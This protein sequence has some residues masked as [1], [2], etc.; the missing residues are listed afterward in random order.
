[1]ASRG[2]R[3][4]FIDNFDS[5]TYN[6]VDEF[7]KRG[8]VVEVYRNNLPLKKIEE[9]VSRFRPELIVISPGPSTPAKAGNS[10]AV[11]K[12]FAGKVPV[13]GV[14]LGEQ[15][16][17]EAFGG[18]V[19]KA[20]ET[21]HGKPSLVTHDGKGI[22]RGLSKPFQAGRYHSLAGQKI[23]KELEVSARSESG[24]VM[25][26][27]HR[28]FFMEGVQFHPESILTPEGGKI[29][30]NVLEMLEGEGKM[31]KEAISKVAEG[32]DLSRA[33]AKEVFDEIM[34]GRTSEDDIVSLLVAL[35]EKG[36]SIGE[37]Q[38]AA[39]SMRSV[40]ARVKAKGDVLDVVGTGGDGKNSFNVS[41]T[42]AIVAAGAGCKVAKHGNRGVSSKSGAADVLQSLGVN[43]ETE[44][45][46]NSEIFEKIGLAF[47]FAPKHHP[48]MK[49]AIG[50]SKRI[51]K[52]TIFNIL[53]PITN[54]A[55]ANTYLLGAYSEGLAE[56]LAFVLSGL[57][58]KKALVVHG[59]GYDEAALTGGTIIFEVSKG[60]V[61]KK[62]INPE[63]FGFKRCGEKDLE[64]SSP[65]ESAEIVKKILSG[66]EKGPKA[67]VVALN[68]GL[69]IYAFGE[70]LDFGAGIAMA[71]R[72]IASG[73]ALE[74]LEALIRESNA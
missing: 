39:E 16:M 64:I 36:E 18:V 38:G 31:I 1:M 32:N 53:G 21:I 47:M 12:K 49:Y 7:E 4:L 11:I 40:V 67:D 13:L 68:A 58:T 19:G 57:G 30:E 70:A 74:K 44:P 66:G 10:I 60:K 33:E 28:K 48:A 51:G 46:R 22:F 3:I 35:S 61:E 45:Q 20:V 73:K 54:P 8:C 72:S 5:F 2:R 62:E 42:A 63:M 14:C 52:R 29:I 43:I 34:T 50:A 26:V 23:P 9:I 65:E 27:R 55:G 15:A 56:K 6:L 41:T 69:A 25:G 37:I 17:I 59:S 71:K 24:V